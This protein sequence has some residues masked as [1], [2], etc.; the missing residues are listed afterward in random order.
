M[1]FCFIQAIERGDAATYGT[2]LNS[3]RHAI[4]TVGTKTNNT[5]GD[6]STLM[7]MLVAGGSVSGGLTQ[8][9]P[10]LMIV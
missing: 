1:T 10:P 9:P 4:R 6:P 8:V 2:I 7:N 5:Y 3:M